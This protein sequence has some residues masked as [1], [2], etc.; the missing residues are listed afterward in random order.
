MTKMWLSESDWQQPL[1]LGAES[2]MSR[3]FL[4]VGRIF[5]ISSLCR[6]GIVIEMDVS[7]QCQARLE[8]YSLLHKGNYRL[9]V[10]G[11]DTL[12][13]PVGLEPGYTNLHTRTSHSPSASSR[14]S[15]V[16]WP[17]HAES[18]KIAECGI[19]QSFP[20]LCI[21]LDEGLCAK[22]QEAAGLG[23]RLISRPA[24]WSEIVSLTAHHIFE[25]RKFE[26]S[27]MFPNEV[28]LQMKER[29]GLSAY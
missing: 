9:F 29:R 16:V 4:K 10:D 13:I 3:R 8:L 25:P 21:A 17:L 2:D 20:C 22:L 23:R 18:S 12:R 19:R 26:I 6:R 24:A 1:R 7:R 15:N 5:P 27:A 28:K 11:V 14:I